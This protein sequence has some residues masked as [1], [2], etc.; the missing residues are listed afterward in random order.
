MAVIVIELDAPH[1]DLVN[2]LAGQDVV[3]CCIIPDSADS[4]KALADA[5]KVAGVKRFLPSAFATVCPPGGIMTLRE[6]VRIHVHKFGEL[7]LTSKPQKEDVINHIKKIYLPYTIIDVGWWYQ[8]TLPRLPS[9]KID[10]AMKF[11]VTTIAGDGNFPTALTDLRDV[12]KYVA[13]IIA[14]PRTLNKSIFVHSEVRTQNQIFALL[15]KASGETIPREYQSPSEVEAAITA[16]RKAYYEQQDRS[17]A[18]LLVLTI[19]QYPNSMW[20]RGDNTPEAAAYLGYLSGKELYP[21]MQTEHVKFEE[22]VGEMLAG[23]GRAPY[24]NRTFPCESKVGG[25]AK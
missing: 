12:G 3:I 6:I 8:G 7:L 19:T 25:D 5:A 16:A 4:Q 18:D 24:A 13:R 10:Y 21:D 15:E 9:G 22:Y 14:D 1:E 11:P 17:F 20:L 23:K 2:A